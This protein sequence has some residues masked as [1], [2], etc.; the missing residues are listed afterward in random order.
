M[1][2]PFD[3]LKGTVEIEA[4]GYYSERFL[5]LCALEKI[6]LKKLQKP[7]ST[8]VIATVDLEGY[9]QARRIAK[10]TKCR[11]KIIKKH[12]LPF[13]LHRY[14]K[15]KGF[16]IGFLVALLLFYFLTTFV[17]RIEIDGNVGL[18]DEQILA[19]LGENG[20]RTGMQK[21]RLDTEKTE[22]DMML[23]VPELVWMNIEVKGTTVYVF[24]KERD[25][26]PPIVAEDVPADIKAAKDG[27]IQSVIAKEGTAV[28]HPGDT[29]MKGQLL[30]SSIMEGREGKLRSVHA[31][32]EVQARTFYEKSDTASTVKV[33]KIYTGEEK[34]RYTLS[35]FNFSLKF[36]LNSSNPYEECD[37]ITENKQF[38]IGRYYFLPIGLTKE[39]YREYVTETTKVSRDEAVNECIKKLT[40]ELRGKLPPEVLS[41][42]PHTEVID[43]EDGTARV[44]VVLECIE[45]IAVSE[46]AESEL[47]EE[48]GT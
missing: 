20:I 40:E 9:Y 42:T 6:N 17:W 3:F 34:S 7:E 5:N 22:L 38:A 25:F 37:K 4:E 39:T 27:V 31:Q 26:S 1:K 44:R 35:L 10:K 19:S 36:H 28:V 33:N 45:N 13:W 12:G 15:R 46:E 43:Q 41:V 32:G 21:F 14:R 29:V 24:L 47:T 18:T 11:L 8:K 16:L 48:E 30:I 2:V 23:K